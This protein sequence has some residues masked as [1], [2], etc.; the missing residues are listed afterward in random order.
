MKPLN[1]YDATGSAQTGWHSTVK[2][3]DTAISSLQDRNAKSSNSLNAVPSPFSRLHIFETA[4]RLVTKDIRENRD[5]A[6]R[7]YKD[8]V[9]D[10]LDAI[11]LLFNSA[12]HESQGDK[13]EFINWKASHLNGLNTDAK[14]QQIFSKTLSLFLEQDLQSP[15]QISI[16]K[17]KG[18]AIAGGSPYT[19][20]FTS[21]NLDK[22]VN[23]FKNKHYEHIFDLINPGT[24]ALYFK[25]YVPFSKRSS[26]FKKYIAKFFNDNVN[27]KIQFKALWDY[28]DIEDIRKVN[29]EGEQATKELRCIN[30]GFVQVGDIYLKANADAT[31]ID[32][33]NDVLIKVAYKLDSL[34]FQTAKYLN[35][36]QS[37]NFDFLLPLKDSVAKSYDLNKIS[38]FISYEI[39][40]TNT[41]KVIFNDGKGGKAKSK[42]FTSSTPN[43]NEGRIVDLSSEF[44]YNFTLGIFPFVR[45]VDSNNELLPKYNNYYKILLGIDS[46]THE[47]LSSD[48]FS[49][50]FYRVGDSDF[51]IISEDGAIY[52]SKRT[53]RRRFETPDSLTSI[54]YQVNNSTF[55]MIKLSL[56][57]GLHL[58]QIEGLIIPKWK[59]RPI[60]KTSFDFSVDFGTTNT[61]IAYTNDRSEG[62]VP[63]PFDITLD[64]QQ[65]VLIQKRED[66]SGGQSV[67]STFMKGNTNLLME[68][69]INQEFIPPVLLPREEGSPFKMPFRTA[70]YQQKNAKEYSIFNDINIHF[71]YQKIPFGEQAQS[72]NEIIPNIKWDITDKKDIGSKRRVESYINEICH[73][74]KYKVLLNDGDPSRTKISWFVPQSLS[75]AAI[76]SYKEIWN[77]SVETVFGSI[78]KSTMV[79]E[80]EAP[81]Y[82]LRKSAAIDDSSSVLSIDIGGGSTDVMLFVNHLPRVGTS[83]NF[84]GNVLWGNGYNEFTNDAREN[85]FYKAISKLVEDEIKRDRTLSLNSQY[86]AKKSTEEIIN[87]WIANSDKIKIDDYLKADE[88]KI[89][90]LFHYCSLIFHITQLVKTANMAAPT[91]LIFSGNGSKYLNALG[92]T[93][94]L[95]KI[96]GFI[97]NRL[98]KQ[99]KASPQIILPNK[100]RKEATCYGGI[101]KKENVDFISKTHIGTTENFQ[102]SNGNVT[103]NEIENKL[104]SIKE[105]VISNVNELIETM[106]ELNNYL[107]FKSHLNIDLDIGAIKNLINSK[108]S[109]FF[110]KGYNI[111]KEKIEFD[112]HV[113][114][115]LFFYPLTGVI[116]EL[117]KVTKETLVEFVPK[118]IK[119]SGA[120]SAENTFSSVALDETK[121]LNSIFKISI[122]V[123]NP[124]EADFEIIEEPSVYHRAYMST[125][126][127]LSPVSDCEKFPTSTSNLMIR[128]LNKGKL[129]RDGDNW[130]VT[131]RLKIEF[132]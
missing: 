74:L 32:I 119:F 114:D 22:G 34:N 98:Y 62:S 57:P 130:I 120:P 115:S 110:D 43:K 76:N 54:Y 107:P 128:Q 58:N 125:E 44:N 82:F 83:F 50:S 106:V 17:Y 117:S 97:I 12:F 72:T 103:Y 123:N 77:K 15:D 38:S 10:C 67:T 46:P 68:E 70:V 63:K 78:A 29:I 124:N 99:Q 3:N 36:D 53:V 59:S 6:S 56:Q 94:L 64:D 121:N 73:L 2:L 75:Y 40:G 131:E 49:L 108:L 104:T 7:V 48:K 45:I 126:H 85:G 66:A 4:F 87:F 52:N 25:K 28:L 42:I 129:R 1:I 89:V 81:Y 127:I 5:R 16:I 33:F 96:T 23:A 112:E 90:Y 105:S 26:Q 71:A 8:L 30:G 69:V 13:L 61:F 100:D 93:A 20:L 92:D 27:A 37:R 9:S 51:E 79:Y 18:I 21:P 65:L 132:I 24:G 35:D 86:F 39:I 31:A 118:L 111:R 91:C 47:A 60:G 101:Y 80:S 102:F 84:A 116:Y 109:S 88:F 95:S 113:S 11:E 41:V 19:I 122:P 55:D 14:G